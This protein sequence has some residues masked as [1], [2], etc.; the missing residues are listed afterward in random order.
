MDR[1]YVE[2]AVVKNQN[3]S[4]KGFARG[5][6][7]NCEFYDCVFS[8]ADLSES[9]FQNCDFHRCDLSMVKLHNTA[10]RDVRFKECKQLGSRFDHCNKMLL[11]FSFHNCILNFSSF[12]ALNLKGIIF[13]DCQMHEVDLVQAEMNNACFKGSDLLHAMF[14]HTAL[15]GADFRDAVNFSIDPENNRIKKSKFSSN[16]LSGLLDKYNLQIE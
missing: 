6:Y 16:G 8:N 13:K 2:G 15:E 11:S 7:E 14:D 1:E 5:E 4:D 12:F 9:I 10:L 3:F